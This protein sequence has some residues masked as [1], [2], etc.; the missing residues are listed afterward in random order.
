[1]INVKKWE[2]ICIHHSSSNDVSRETVNSWHRMRGWGKKYL[3]GIYS[4]GYHFLVHKDGIIETGRPLSISGA[5]AKGYNERL[6]GLCVLGNFEVESPSNEQYVITAYLITLLSKIYNF[7]SSKVYFHRD[8]S[9]TNCPG[10][11]FNK[12]ILLNISSYFAL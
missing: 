5:H 12:N 7:D 1:M 2:G 4:I 10:K 11:N 3:D 8:I 6:I 9:N